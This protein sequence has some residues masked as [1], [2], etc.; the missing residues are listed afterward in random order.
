MITVTGVNVIPSLHS[1]RNNCNNI[2]CC[3]N[4]FKLS[5]SLIGFHVGGSVA[6]CELKGKSV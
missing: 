3:Q 4:V 5:L 6:Y 2:N 1:K